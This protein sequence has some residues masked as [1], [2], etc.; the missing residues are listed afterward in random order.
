[1]SH[2]LAKSFATDEFRFKYR[3]R[4]SA[5]KVWHDAA[6]ETTPWIVDP[7]LPTVIHDLEAYVDILLRPIFDSKGNKIEELKETWRPHCDVTGNALLDDEGNPLGARLGIVGPS[8]TIVQDHEV[9][10]WFR[11]WID[12]K[13]ATIETG[14][15]LF[16]GSR[17]WLLA[18][19]SKDAADV[20]PGDAIEQYV[21]VINGHDGRLSF[22]PVPTTIRVICNNTAEIAMRSHLAKRFKRRHNAHIHL[23]IEEVREEVEEM[24]GLFLDNLE[25]F[26]ALAAADVKSEKDLKTYF[27]MVLKSKVDP[28]EEIKDD[29]KRPLP[30]L[31]RLFNGE[32]T[33]LDIKGVANT[34]WAADSMISGASA[35]MIERALDIGLQAADTGLPQVATN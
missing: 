16:G 5:P 3:K 7:D 4:N 2:E 30:T 10:N 15:A 21:M 31:M 17:F 32:G 6:T 9:V 8:Y 18:R 1:M 14:G 19:L 23:R 20:V 28:D 29:G 13:V 34:Y 11:P 24:E 27:Q 35:Q 33:G 22:W 12:G 25:K 26:K